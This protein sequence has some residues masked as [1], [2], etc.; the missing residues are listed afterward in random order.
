MISLLTSF[1]T[2]AAHESHTRIDLHTGSDKCRKPCPQMPL[3]CTLVC[4]HTIMLVSNVFDCPTACQIREQQRFKSKDT[5]ERAPAEANFKAR[6]EAEAEATAKTKGAVLEQQTFECK[7]AEDKAAAEAKAAVES[8]TGAA[9]TAKKT[10]T[11]FE[12]L[13]ACF[14]NLRVIPLDSKVEINVCS[15]AV[16]VPSA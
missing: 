13:A 2:F 11:V 16:A 9:A 8:K 3:P 12:T 6:A 14:K 4:I 1:L 15:D 5:Q 10:V 7:E